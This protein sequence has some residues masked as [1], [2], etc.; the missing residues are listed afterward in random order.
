MFTDH[1]YT[2]SEVIVLKLPLLRQANLTDLNDRILS[3]ME[4]ETQNIKQVSIAICHIPDLSDEGLHL[5]MVITADVYCNFTR[6]LHAT[7]RTF[8]QPY[9]RT[10]HNILPVPFYVKIYIY[11][12]A[13]RKIIV[14]YP[15]ICVKI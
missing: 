11:P 14:D 9:L 15:R 8:T 3:N 4:D 1:P 7:I 12:L 13:L 10:I 6:T 2:K 5:F